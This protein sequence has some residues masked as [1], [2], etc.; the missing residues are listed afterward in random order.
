[1][2]TR[3][4][5]TLAIVAA[6]IVMFSAMWDPRVSVAVSIITLLVFGIFKFTQKSG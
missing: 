4:E 5:A 3:I 2:N 1:M 6:L